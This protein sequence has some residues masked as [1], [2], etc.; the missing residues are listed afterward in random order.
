M[1]IISAK[2]VWFIF[3]IRI[4]IRHQKHLRCWLSPHFMTL[5]F[6]DSKQQI[7][8]VTVTLK[9]G[10]ANKAACP[11]ICIARRNDEPHIL[12]L[13]QLVWF[14]TPL[15]LRHGEPRRRQI[16][17]DTD[18]NKTPLDFSQNNHEVRCFCRWAL[19]V[20]QDTQL[21]C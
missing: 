10:S 15:L 7:F 9:Y 19:A 17:L 8:N 5:S 16:S 14:R 6:T 20:M 4:R 11:A 18:V 2:S 3:N 1:H 12:T 13:M 21:L